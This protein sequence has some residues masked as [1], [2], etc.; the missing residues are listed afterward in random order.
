MEG[1]WPTTAVLLVGLYAVV[2][3]VPCAAY[4]YLAAPDW[5]LLYLAS[6]ANVPRLMVVPICTLAVGALFAGFH[7]GARLLRSARELLPAQVPHSPEAAAALRAL[8]GPASGRLAEVGSTAAYRAGTA[9]PLGAVK[10]GYV[11]PALF[12]GVVAAAGYTAWELRRDARRAS[13]R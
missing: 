5:A 6:S 4:L 11:L 8:L 7:G 12:L 3:V 2:V 9:L 1:R 13:A 10:L